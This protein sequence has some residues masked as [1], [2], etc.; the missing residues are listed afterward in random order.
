MTK[1]YMCKYCGRRTTVSGP[2]VPLKT[3]CPKHLHHVWVIVK[4]EK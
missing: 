1:H 3:K 4:K 2:R